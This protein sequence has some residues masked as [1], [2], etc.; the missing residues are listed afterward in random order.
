M[1]A[2]AGHMRFG[3]VVDG[4]H[5][6]EE[7]V[8]KP[9]GRHMRQCTYLAGATILGDGQAA[10]ILDA[11]G[12][13]VFSKLRAP[14]E[15]TLDAADQDAAAGTGD[16]QTLL[17]LRND[18]AEQFA[19]PMQLVARLERIRS[20]QIDSVG[21]NKVLQYR[22]SSLPL[23]A[24]EDLISARPMPES[25]WLYVVVS[26]L[27]GR[28]VGL[29]IREVIDIRTT[30]APIDGT[31]FREPGVTGSAVIEGK[32]TRLLDL[33][34]LTAAAH[35]GWVEN[36]EKLKVAGQRGRAAAGAAGGRE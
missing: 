28:E 14:E 31:L 6:S 29:L 32:A 17:L 7:I 26:T 8:V 3:L 34:E 18:P 12:I 2:E 36:A 23:L 19:V 5:D 35:P 10:L 4:L 27:G 15:E 11:A 22:G 1:V 25:D 24:L 30:D 21:G 16:A 33:Y 20:L 13:A 9:L